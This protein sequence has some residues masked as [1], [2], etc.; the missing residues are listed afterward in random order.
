MRYIK[1]YES[2]LTD[3][4]SKLIKSYKDYENHIKNIKDMQ[5]ITK[6]KEL[7]IGGNLKELGNSIYEIIDDM[8]LELFDHYSML[9]IGSRTENKVVGISRYYGVNSSIDIKIPLGDAVLLVCAI[10]VKREDYAEFASALKEFDEKL[11]NRFG[12]VMYAEYRCDRLIIGMDIR[13]FNMIE[14]Q[15]DTKESCLFTINIY[16]KNK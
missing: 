1:L 4:N 12:D 14:K 3:L 9:E 15:L 10:P 2:V 16:L 8:T 11:I 13:D 7:V 6:E 5:K